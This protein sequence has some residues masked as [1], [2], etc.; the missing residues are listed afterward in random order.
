MAVEASKGKMNELAVRR[1]AQ[2]AKEEKIEQEARALA[3]A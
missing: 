3:A 1:R 2:A